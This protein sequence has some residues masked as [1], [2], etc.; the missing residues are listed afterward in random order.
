MSFLFLLLFMIITFLQ[1]QE[2]IPGIKG[3]PLAY[4]TMLLLAVF[5]IFRIMLTQNFNFGRAQ[6]NLLMIFLWGA[7]V[8]STISVGWVS[9]TIDTFLEWA[10]I[11][12]IYFLTISIIEN[13]KQLLKILRI[14]VFAM[15]INSIMGILQYYGI[16]FT[17]VGMH[18]EGR[19][20]GV[21]IFDTNQ[22]AYGLCY[23]SPFIFLFIKVNKNMIKKIL[24]F[25]IFLSYL[26]CIYLTQSRGGLI[27]FIITVFLIMNSFTNK[28]IVKTFSFFLSFL[29]FIVLI[30]IVPRFSSTFSYQEDASALGRIDAWAN[31]LMIWKTTPIWGI[32]KGQFYEH[33]K[34]AAHSSYIEVLTEVGIL[35]L[36]L[37]ISLFYYSFKNLNKVSLT[38]LSNNISSNIAWSAR[39][40][41]ISLIAYLIGSYFSSSAYYIPLFILFAFAVVVQRWAASSERSM[42]TVEDILKILGIV[43]CIILLIHIVARTI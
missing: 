26:Y 42:F 41:R 32:G 37:W 1:P 40:I 43:V 23:T 22:L 34:I 20:R 33:F 9:Y 7:I 3:F 17:G 15:T 35:G 31:G 21:G 13:E 12:I 39:T 8:L 27:C 4:F 29:I 18:L 11:V 36:F 6:Q 5:W 24:Y 28:N 19:I 16:D 10:K 2:F 38:S 25:L 30:K 14:I